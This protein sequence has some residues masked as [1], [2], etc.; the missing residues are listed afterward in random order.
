MM[1]QLARQKFGNPTSSRVN[2]IEDSRHFG[3]EKPI[4][5]SK[6]SDKGSKVSQ[7][8][9]KI[10]PPRQTKLTL[11]RA[12]YSKSKLV[13]TTPTENDL[14]SESFFKDDTISQE[15]FRT[16][17][18]KISFEK[19]LFKTTQTSEINQSSS[20]DCKFEPNLTHSESS[21]ESKILLEIS[22]TEL[23]CIVSNKSQFL[24][25]KK[26][27]ELT[28]TF[29]SSKDTDVISANVSNLIVNELVENV[30]KEVFDAKLISKL[31][32]LEMKD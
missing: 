23:D 17:T 11:S 9:S 3:A 26:D 13:G 2:E 20:E 14:K 5:S 16:Q 31:I 8:S 12:Q 22:D 32:Q 18:S 10:K 25:E 4:K 24:N 15:S 21:S 30:C 27:I 7:K 19:K 6:E 1:N 28:S 29:F